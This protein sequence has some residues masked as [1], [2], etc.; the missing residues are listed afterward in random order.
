MQFGIGGITIPQDGGR[1][2]KR[3]NATTRTTRLKQQLAVARRSNPV[4]AAYD[5]WLFGVKPP[6]QPKTR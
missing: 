3:V 2:T 6:G 5:F 4:E 1:R